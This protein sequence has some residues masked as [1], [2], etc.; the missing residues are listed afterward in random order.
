ML[1][2]AVTIVDLV[3]MSL[4]VMHYA[5]VLPLPWGVP[6]CDG[7][8]F[9]ELGQMFASTS[10]SVTPPAKVQQDQIK[11]V[12][13]VMIKYRQDVLQTFLVTGTMFAIRL[14]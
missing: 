8:S 5:L 13:E 12:K 1:S 10:N 6:K 2:I 14:F 3:K 7:I 11:K 9:F 4:T